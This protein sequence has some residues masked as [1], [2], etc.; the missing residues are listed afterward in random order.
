MSP[1]LRNLAQVQAEFWMPCYTSSN[2]FLIAVYSLRTFSM[3][4]T[5]SFPN[6]WETLVGMNGSPWISWCSRPNGLHISCQNL[7]LDPNNFSASSSQGWQ[8][9][10]HISSAEQRENVSNILIVV[11][12]VFDQLPNKHLS[13]IPHWMSQSPLVF[14][15]QESGH[16]NSQ[17][18]QQTK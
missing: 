5:Q 10:H 14:L 1:P 9:W 4:K 18:G 7:E 15:V 8:C 17:T 11:V 2:S 3:N 16:T 13:A 6:E 12:Q